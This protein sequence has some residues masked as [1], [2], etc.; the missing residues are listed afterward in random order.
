MLTFIYVQPIVNTS[1]INSGRTTTHVFISM[2]RSMV[3][4]ACL[5]PMVI[6]VYGYVHYS[7][8]CVV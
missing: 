3:I 1:S 5:T 8:S 7:R 2:S 6:L 4:V